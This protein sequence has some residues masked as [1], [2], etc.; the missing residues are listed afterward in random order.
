V[1]FACCESCGSTTWTL[2]EMAAGKP[3]GVCPD[4]GAKAVWMATP[5]AERVPAQRRAVPRPKAVIAVAR[6][7]R[8]N[9][10]KESDPPFDPRA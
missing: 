1:A 5:F 2:G 6:S 3:A 10:T 4:C 9:L 8:L 7:Q